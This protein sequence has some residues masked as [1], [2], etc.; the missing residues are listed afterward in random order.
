MPLPNL[1][2]DGCRL[3][4]VAPHADDE[5]L[6][7]GG[8]IAH[9]RQSNCQVF[10]LFVTLSGYAPLT[11]GQPATHQ[12]REAE[13]ESAAR[14][15][16]IAGYDVLYRNGNH[17]C[18]LDT[19]PIKDLIDWLETGSR[20]AF[21]KVHPNVILLPSAHHTHQDHRRVHEAGM[22]VA[23]ANPNGHIPFRIVLEYEVPGTGLAGNGA[24]NPDFYLALAPSE[25][26]MKCNHFAQYRS[27]VTD[28]PH[29]RSLQAIRTLAEFRGME[30]GYQFAEAYR[31][32]RFQMGL[33]IRECNSK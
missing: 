1:F 29:L 15:A 16:Q 30:A 28:A 26:E 22:T 2:G 33:N 32:V 21:H 18:R 6:G 19:V 17:H 27:Q 14:H 25:L 9:A 4:I 5:A 10:V 23:R 13:L 7:C 11:A 3:W 8:I 20:Y 24:F 12:E 31:N